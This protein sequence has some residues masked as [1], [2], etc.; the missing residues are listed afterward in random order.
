[1]DHI[2]DGSGDTTHKDWQ[3]SFTEILNELQKYVRKHFPQGI[4]WNSDG[5]PA[6]TFIGATVE[7]PPPA[8]SVAPP[9]PPP[10]PPCGRPPLPPPS[11][12][13]SRHPLQQV[14]PPLHLPRHLH[15][16]LQNP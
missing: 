11:H 15:H 6:D 13:L 5:L 14:E 8:P 3:T 10:P 12:L 1:M 16:L 7:V 2:A 4:K 9:V